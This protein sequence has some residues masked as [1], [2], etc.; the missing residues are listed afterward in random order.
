MIVPPGPG[1]TITGAPGV[2][3]GATAVCC[4]CGW[5][6]GVDCGAVEGFVV[7]STARGEPLACGAVEAF[8]MLSTARRNT[9]SFRAAAA[10]SDSASTFAPFGGGADAEGGCAA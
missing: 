10:L 4:G 8:E 1:A 5:R 7:L 3:C 2:L 9:L 6:F